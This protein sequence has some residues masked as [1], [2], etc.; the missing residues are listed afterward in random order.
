[1]K[2]V[3]E[4]KEVPMFL[5]VAFPTLEEFREVIRLSVLDSIR[6][7]ELMAKM[8]K[9]MLSNEAAAVRKEI[10]EIGHCA[11][12]RIKAAYDRDPFS[13]APTVSMLMSLSFAR[14]MAEIIEESDR[15]LTPEQAAM[16]KGTGA[17]AELI[18]GQSN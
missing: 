10:Q 1:M 16:L 4:I 11:N 3:S 5:K 18:T 12:G 6:T 7:D 9:P 13:H 8:L 17:F 15:S 14:V 2:D